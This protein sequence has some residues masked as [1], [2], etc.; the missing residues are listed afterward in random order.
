MA[1]LSKLFKSGKNNGTQEVPLAQKTDEQRKETALTASDTRTRV[2]AI[3]LI[4]EVAI[5]KELAFKSDHSP[6]EVT[7]RRKLADLVKS[8]SVSFSEMSASNPPM[9]ALFEIAIQCHSP[10]DLANIIPQ[11]NDQTILEDLALNGAIAQLRQV[12]ADQITSQESLER[13]AKATKGKDKSVFR[14]CKDKLDKIKAQKQEVEQKKQAL[15]QQV[16]SLEKLASNTL[17]PQF[18]IK[19]KALSDQWQHAQTDT[20]PKLKKRGDEALTYCQSV[21]DKAEAERLAAKEEQ[22]QQEQRVHLAN[23]TRDNL[24]TELHEKSIE[25]IN[26]P[27]FEESHYQSA[28]D[29]ADEITQKWQESEKEQPATKSDIKAF[30]HINTEYSAMAVTLKEYGSIKQQIEKTQQ[31]NDPKNFDHLDQLI[32]HLDFLDV[33]DRPDILIQAQELLQKHHK[34]LSDARAHK[35]SLI[36]QIRGLIRKCQWAIQQGHLRQATGIEH[37]IEEKMSQLEQVPHS[38]TRQVETLL[39][40]LNKLRDWQS[41]AVQPKKEALVK[42]MESLVGNDQDPE[43]LSKTI[44]KLQDDWKALS[45]GGQNQHQELWDR[46]HEAAQKAYEPCKAFFNEQSQQRKQNLKKRAELVEQL[47]KLFDVTDWGNP[48]WNEVEQTLHVARNEWRSYSPV[49]RAANKSIQKDFDK[50]IEAFQSHLDGH[51]QT[52]KDTKLALIE[53]TKALLNEENVRQATENAKLIQEEWKKSG[54]TWRKDEQELWKKFRSICDDLF[55]RR[56]EKNK[57]FRAELDEH[58][59]AAMSALESLE[60]LVNDENKSSSEKQRLLKELTEQFNSAGQLPRQQSDKVNLRWKEAVNKLNQA[61]KAEKNQAVLNNWLKAE[62]ILDSLVTGQSNVVEKDILELKLKPVL[63][64]TLGRNLNAKSRE[65][66]TARAHEYCVLAEALAGID[67]PAEDEALR[68][69]LQVKRLKAG[70]GADQS[71][72]QNEFE[73][74]QENWFSLLSVDSEKWPGLKQ[75]FTAAKTAYEQASK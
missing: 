17:N 68:M 21:L 55:A 53:K 19:F 18:E 67:S 23:T 54:R 22:E 11:F 14:I 35:Q 2:E 7:A 72:K 44:R 24:I 16:E 31:S 65:D 1:V 64:E 74:L 42:K 8:G 43:A 59:S 51:F 32:H 12:S 39:E 52:V 66:Q 41:Y 46:F 6:V 73:T 47:N 70:I 30:S 69:D 15:T 60:S 10:E 56:E 37:S 4:E 58:L 49:E 20:F 34:E 25:L 40:S 57:A 48:V 28:L 61:I 29:F 50:I 45:K 9:A 3:Q 71:I 13:I 5:L 75:R 36:R 26:L 27:S 33:S 38:L 63:K 62:A